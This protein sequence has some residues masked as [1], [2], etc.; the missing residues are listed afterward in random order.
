M[1]TVEDPDVKVP[2][3]LP[4]DPQA[5]SVDLPSFILGSSTNVLVCVIH[6]ADTHGD[7]SVS[8]GSGTGVT[9]TVRTRG[10]SMAGTRTNVA[11]ALSG[12]VINKASSDG[13]IVPSGDS[14]TVRLTI[15][16]TDNGGNNSCSNGT[17]KDVEI[18]DVGFDKQATVLLD[19]LANN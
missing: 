14:R 3:V 19:L 8:G 2:V 15:S 13:S 5:T 16:N 12:I 4:V 18:S 1:V 17:T 6:T 9:R 11:S 7:L 10:I